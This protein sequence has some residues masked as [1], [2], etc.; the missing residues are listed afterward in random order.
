MLQALKHHA[1]AATDLEQALELQPGNKA[2]AKELDQ[3]KQD[4]AEHSKQR[5]V[6]K[7]LSSTNIP[8]SSPV[9]A[10]AG[11]SGAEGHACAA[12]SQGPV[13]DLQKLQQLMT[14]LQSAGKA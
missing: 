12:A 2:F 13:Q 14:S 3:L 5:S 11:Q 4:C 10:P 6:L 9:S 7:Q 1:E 8:S